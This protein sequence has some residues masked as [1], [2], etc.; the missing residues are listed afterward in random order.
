[1]KTIKN[2]IVICLLLMIPV[3]MFSAVFFC[4]KQKFYKEALYSMENYRYEK[5]YEQFLELK[6]Y[7]DSE[8]LAEEMLQLTQVSKSEFIKLFP[9]PDRNPN[10]SYTV[11]Y[12]SAEGRMGL[13]FDYG[14]NYGKDL[15]AEWAKDDETF[16]GVDRNLM[17][18]FLGPDSA[19][20]NGSQYVRFDPE[21]GEFVFTIFSGE[22][23]KKY[24][25][26]QEP[27]KELLR[28]KL[29]EDGSLDLYN[30]AGDRYVF[31]PYCYE[32]HSKMET[33][34]VAP[35]LTDSVTIG[36]SKNR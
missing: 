9:V 26:G 29:L 16:W 20:H 3:S 14:L 12:W 24:A 31:V 17:N 34:I 33:I 35:E 2:M 28:G 25:V 5:A 22:E 36:V 21:K 13:K 15:Y 1:M 18:L 32:D 10:R 4:F 23:E 11:S 6:G 19:N 30:S 27:I 7:R 8:E